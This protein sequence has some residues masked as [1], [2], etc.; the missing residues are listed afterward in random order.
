VFLD[1]PQ[2]VLSRGQILTLTQGRTAD[3]YDRS[4]GLLVS[5]LRQR[6]R[7]GGAGAVLYQDRS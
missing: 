4:V 7:D 1:H 3:A 2:P 6:L 5:R